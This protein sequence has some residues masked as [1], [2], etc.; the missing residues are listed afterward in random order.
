MNDITIPEYAMVEMKVVTLDGIS[1]GWGIVHEPS[2]TVYQMDDGRPFLA[3]TSECA[4]GLVA[5]LN[6]LKSAPHI[7][8]C[9]I[10]N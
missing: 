4:L 9:F 2:D 8:Q 6:G 1:E 10:D 7:C 5:I 3:R